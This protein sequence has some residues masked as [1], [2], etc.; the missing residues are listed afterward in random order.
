MCDLILCFR[1]GC[2]QNESYLYVVRIT[3]ISPA[4]ATLRQMK[5]GQIFLQKKF[6][7]ANDVPVKI[8]IPV[9]PFNI[10]IKYLWQKKKNE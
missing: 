10:K 8:N 3:E 2:Q 1:V 6:L 9:K 7:Q 5:I 4:D